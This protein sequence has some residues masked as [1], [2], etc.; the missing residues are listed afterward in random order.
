MDM[1]ARIQQALEQELTCALSPS[2]P[3][4][5]MAAMR[6]AVFPGGARIRPQLCLAVAQACGDDAPELTDAAAVAIELLH[7]ASLVHDDMPCFDD[8][9][10]R[11]GLPSV[12]KLHGEPL[13][14]LSGDGLIV[15]A[16][17]AMARA[18]A[19]HPG[20]LTGLLATLCSAAGAPD[21]IVAGQAWECE[22]RASLSRYQRAKTGALFVASTCAGAQAAGADPQGW[23]SLGE[24]LGEA[25]QVADDIRDVMLGSDE[26]GKP[27]GQDAQHHR[28]SAADDLGLAGALSYFQQLM[29]DAVDAVPYC[30]HRGAMRALVLQESARLIPPDTCE[31]IA[32]ATPSAPRAGFIPLRSA[33]A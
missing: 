31:R 8:A 14:L 32:S 13:A 30:A 19:R 27:S 33:V 26:L 5:L 9:D 17:Q 7:C 2:A 11:R 1:L 10:L 3:P 23:R 18:G 6:H 24:C 16:F 29:Q 21:G 22:P 20:R 12:H 28:P 25:Y 4:R 15:M